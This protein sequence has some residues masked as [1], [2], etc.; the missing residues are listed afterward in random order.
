MPLNRELILIRV[1]QIVAVILAEDGKPCCE[2]PTSALLADMGVDSVSI[3]EILQGIEVE[4]GLKI[5]EHHAAEYFYSIDSIVEFIDS[6]Y[7][8]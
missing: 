3:V 5:P 1:R 6:P 4:F 7:S 2:I 8:G